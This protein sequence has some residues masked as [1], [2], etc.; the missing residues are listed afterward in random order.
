MSR[1][2][3]VVA[4]AKLLTVGIEISEFDHDLGPGVVG[5]EKGQGWLRFLMTSVLDKLHLR[6]LGERQ[7]GLSSA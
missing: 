4:G 7:V 3:A 1:Q 6:C 2:L 5:K